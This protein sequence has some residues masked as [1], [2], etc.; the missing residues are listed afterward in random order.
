M[1]KHAIWRKDKEQRKKM[2]EYVNSN[3]IEGLKGM[4]SFSNIRNF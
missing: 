4:H 2:K 1:I 3:Y